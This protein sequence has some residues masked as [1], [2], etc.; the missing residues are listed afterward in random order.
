MNLP[1]P[2][3]LRPGRCMQPRAAM[4][5]FQFKVKKKKG[6]SSQITVHFFAPLV[7]GIEKTF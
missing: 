7:S 5:L 4:H 3:Q 6:G 1:E 2:K